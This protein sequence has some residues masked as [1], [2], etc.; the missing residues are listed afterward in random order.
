MHNSVELSRLFSSARQAVLGTDSDEI[1]FANPR[2][3][4]ALGF[5]PTGRPAADIIPHEILENPSE[6]FVCAA[7]LAG[8]RANIAVS[9]LGNLTILFVE[10]M[11]T[12]K[13][14]M[15]LTRSIISNLRSNMTGLKISVDRC[16]ESFQEGKLP[17]EQ[18]T[19]VLYH[20]YYCLLRTLTQIDSADML[21]R[22]EMLFTPVM[23]DL[24][25]LCAD[26]TDTVMLL[27]ATQDVHICFTTTEAE[28][29]AVVDPARIEQLLLNLVANSLQHAKH[30]GHITLSL[31]KRD[32]SIIL[33]VD[34]DGEGIPQEKLPGIFCL[35]DDVE[36]PGAAGGGLGLGLYISYGIAQLHKGV[37]LIESREGEGTRIRVMLPSDKEPSPKFKTPEAAYRIEGAAT[38]LTELA[39]VLPSSCY[40]PKYED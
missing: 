39:N 6:N 38:V 19:S 40:G 35:P 21:E 28:L 8:R 7:P 30:G 36:E 13:P 24:V 23:T 27:C 11:V 37:L 16:C 31:E 12:E 5:D 22:S 25:K 20:Y 4:A 29:F 14:A 9:R 3:Q 17:N 18:Y 2:A 32:A 10:F 26:L 33:S 1:V 34:D 15:Y